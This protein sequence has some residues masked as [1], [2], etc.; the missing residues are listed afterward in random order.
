MPRLHIAAR[1]ACVQ[2]CCQAVRCGL[3]ARPRQ[4][5]AP[6][7]R[8]V[9]PRG[10]DGDGFQICRQPAAQKGEE[11]AHELSLCAHGGW[12]RGPNSATRGYATS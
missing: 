9:P 12:Q 7:G 8:V 10:A 3:H 11:V 6:F 4:E 1:A 2:L 5:W